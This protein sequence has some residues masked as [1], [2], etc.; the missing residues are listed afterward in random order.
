LGKRSPHSFTPPPPPH[1]SVVGVSN[2]DS[3][4]DDVECFY[5][6]E[7]E[8]IEII[9]VKFDGIYCNDPHCSDKSL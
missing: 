6:S 2:N 8:D 9:C 4:C 1:L 7:E 3:K 5:S